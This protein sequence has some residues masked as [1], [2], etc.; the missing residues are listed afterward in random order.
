MKGILPTPKKVAIF[1][2]VYLTAF[3][4]FQG[5]AWVEALGAA[6]QKLSVVEEVLIYMGSFSGYPFFYLSIEIFGANT[7]SAVGLL[8]NSIIWGL[9]LGIMYNW[10][11]A[12]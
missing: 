6:G 12:K 9:L 10:A 8:L 3:F 1:G 4:L 7:G 11:R 2:F 5:I